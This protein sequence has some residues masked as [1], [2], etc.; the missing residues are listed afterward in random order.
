MAS[1]NLQPN[2]ALLL[3]EERVAYGGTFASYTD[4]LLLTNMN[5][6][7][8]KKSMFARS[9]GARVFPLD[10][11]KVHE[12]TAQAIVGKQTNGTPALE[13]YFL[14]G[15]ESFA[16]QSGG[17]KKVPA[18][19]AKINQVVTGQ[20]PSAGQ[21]AGMAIPGAEMVAGVL[22]DTL[23]VFKAKLGSNAGATDAPVQ[24]AG[25]CG[26]CGAPVTGNRGLAVACGYCGTTQ[27]L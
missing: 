5:L 17:K 15:H 7:L 1:Y 23:G 19:V 12:G 22:K 3:K 21:H 24:V 11:I 26:A 13:V 9:K 16:F 4:E 14:T 18:W 2:E 6:I 20:G 8:V 10:Q 27:Q 25:K